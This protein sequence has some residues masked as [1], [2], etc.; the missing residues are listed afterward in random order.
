MALALIIV[1]IILFV[2]A[3]VNLPVPKVS[4]GWL[5]LA[6]YALAQIVGRF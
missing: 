5:G 1:A 3:A 4:L 2:L 6:F